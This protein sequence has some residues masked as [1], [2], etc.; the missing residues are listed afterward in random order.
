MSEIL[1]EGSG[2]AAHGLDLPDD[3]RGIAEF[4]GCVGVM[5]GEARAGTGKT[6]GD[7]APDLA[8]SARH[9]G[10]AASQAE[11]GK[12]IGHCRTPRVGLAASTAW[13][14]TALRGRQ[15]LLVARSISWAL[16]SSRQQ[17]GS[18]L[19]FAKLAIADADTVLAA[20]RA[21]ERQCRR[22]RWSCDTNELPASAM[23]NRDST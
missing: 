10:S 14:T 13:L 9:Q 23:Q 6:D 19:L 3:G 4:L 21:A 1:S 17:F 5:N 20:A 22:V 15:V 12:G 16:A 8:T 18:V 2:L 7:R 11:W